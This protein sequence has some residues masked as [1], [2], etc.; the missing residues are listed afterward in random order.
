MYFDDEVISGKKLGT[1]KKRGRTPVLNVRKPRKKGDSKRSQK[2]AVTLI[3]T[4]TVVLLAGLSWYGVKWIGSSLFSANNR[5]TIKRIVIKGNAI[6]AQ[7]FIRGEKKINEGTNLFAF[8]IDELRSEFLERAISYKTIQINR[9]LPDTLTVEVEPRIPMARVGRWTS[10]VLDNDGIVF[11]APA[12]TKALPR[13]YGSRKDQLVPGAR[14]RGMSIAALQLLSVC[15]NPQLGLAVESVDVGDAEHIVVQAK[16]DGRS[17]IIE[18]T[19]E[20][21]GMKSA[22]SRLKL[23]KKLGRW[24]QVMQTGEGMKRTKFDGT[25]PDRIYAL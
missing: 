3:A 18:L 11:P 24:V 2:I 19:W 22:E 16:Y 7:D 5:F 10:L 21:M 1:V 17:R 8:D 25:Y 20:G 14:M 12:R 23:L 9:L 6:A 13:I 15:D 4:M